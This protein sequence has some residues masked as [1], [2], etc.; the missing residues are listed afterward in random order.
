MPFNVGDYPA[1]M[2]VDS[3]ERIRKYISLAPWVDP[4][5]AI[6]HLEALLDQIDPLPK[7]EIVRERTPATPARTP[8][9]AEPDPHGYEDHLAW[10]LRMSRQRSAAFRRSR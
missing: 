6:A 5:A 4:A 1:V 2:A 8:R 7:L 3:K 10:A 9:P